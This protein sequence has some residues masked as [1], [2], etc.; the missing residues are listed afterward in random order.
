MQPRRPRDAPRKRRIE[1]GT[2][3]RLA[4]L[5]RARAHSTLE[6]ETLAEA[7]QLSVRSLRRWKEVGPQAADAPVGRPPRA[8]A[9]RRQVARL[10]RRELQRQ[11]WSTGERP[12]A[13]A[14][15]G[16]VTLWEVRSVLAPLKSKARARACRRRERERV[17]TTVHC[18]DAVWAQDATH[19]GRDAGGGEVQ[20]EALRDVASTR[21]LALSIGAPATSAEVIALLEQALVARGGA[22]LVWLTDNGSPYCS[23]ALTAWCTEHDVV[24]LRTLPYTPEHNAACEHGHGELKRE[25]ELGKGTR[26]D[27]LVD[28]AHA[29]AAAR[30]RLDGHR[31]RA[32]RGWKTAVE[33]DR[34]APHWSER[35]DRKAF[36]EAISCALA[37]P[38]LHSLSGRARRRAEREAVLGT[39]ERCHVLSRTR[40]G[41]PIPL[42]IAA[43]IT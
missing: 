5:L 25:A 35:V 19:L 43:R 10:V 14:L 6:L 28:A 31:L 23:A 24:H 16:E 13:R 1:P 18:R 11:G 26:I 34:A 38:V 33:A 8:P 30:E 22:P 20:A 41:A 4:A 27:S 2:R 39:L 37:D 7:H 15:H 21:T 42:S 29:L 32:S 9:R 17:S 40:A 12:I 36:L 3:R